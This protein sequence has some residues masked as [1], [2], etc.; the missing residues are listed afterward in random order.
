MAISIN[1]DQKKPVVKAARD[2]FTN[3]MTSKELATSFEGNVL[4]YEKEI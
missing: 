3:K 4:M 2:F 1:A